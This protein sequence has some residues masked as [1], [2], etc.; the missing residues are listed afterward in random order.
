MKTKKFSGKKV[1]PEKLS[2]SVRLKQ[3]AKTKEKVAEH[4]KRYE[5]GLESYKM[6]LNHLSD[7]VKVFSYSRLLEIQIFKKNLSKKLRQLIVP[8]QG[9]KNSSDSYCANILF[10][11]FGIQ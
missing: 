5:Q 10:K 3:F 1:Y 7:L 4:N 8:L 11:Y 9:C 6:G 2:E